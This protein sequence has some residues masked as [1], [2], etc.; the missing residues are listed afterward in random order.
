MER[1]LLA[2]LSWIYLEWKFDKRVAAP[3]LQSYLYGFKGYDNYTDQELVDEWHRVEASFFKAHDA[4]DLLYPPPPFDP[5]HEWARA[6]TKTVD[7][8]IVVDPAAS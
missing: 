3:L 5:L 7:A 4:G 6:Q 1:L 2:E 8:E